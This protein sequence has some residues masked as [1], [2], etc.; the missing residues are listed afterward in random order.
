MKYIR[1]AGCPPAYAQWCSAATGTDKC[2]WRE[3][4]LTQKT[5]LLDALIAEQGELCAYT[6]RRI[7]RDSSHVEHIKP[8]SLCRSDQRGSD[9]EYRNLVACFPR[10][11]LKRGYRYGAHR[12]DNWWDNDGADFV[13]P[14][15][16]SCEHF[17]QFDLDGEVYALGNRAA[18]R[19]TIEVLGLNHSSLTEDRRRVIEEIIYGPFGDDPMSPANA[20][21]TRDNICRRDGNGRF[22]EFCVALRGA[23]EAHLAALAKLD[24]RR[25]AIRRKRQRV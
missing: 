24:Q 23:L 20:R 6:M 18:A 3:V 17:F 14:L 7:K 9:L 4:T 21:R 16:S 19:T 12:K 22:V 1:K 2:D 5:Q 8:Q 25:K 13:S 15:Q 11:G 10:E